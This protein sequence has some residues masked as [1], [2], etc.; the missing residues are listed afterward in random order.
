MIQSPRPV[1][2]VKVGG[3]LLDWRQFPGEFRRWLA[4]Q[5][6]T[7]HAIVV[8]GGGLAEEIRRVDQIHGLSPRDA[9]WLAAQTMEITA[10]LVA[11]LLSEAAMLRFED[12]K[13]QDRTLPHIAIVDAWR[14]LRDVES[15][16]DGGRLP[17]S[18][19]TTSDSIAARFA[20]AIDAAELVLIKSTLPTAIVEA[21]KSTGQ[22]FKDIVPLAMQT[23]LVDA[24]FAEA[25]SGIRDIRC[26]NLR[27]ANFG[28]L[29][30]RRG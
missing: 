23:G 10:R 17:E 30:L 15:N 7:S 6:R 21:A 29:W 28:E 9:H 8:G 14:F 20:V 3:S 2:V 25:S 4:T 12:F 22:S 24:A 26:V 5:P 1:R 13:Q 18:W 16:L 19:A 11:K 27:D